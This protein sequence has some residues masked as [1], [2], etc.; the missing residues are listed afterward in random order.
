MAAYQ[1]VFTT[2]LCD[3]RVLREKPVG[4]PKALGRDG[5]L[6]GCGSIVSS[7]VEGSADHE[8]Q[9]PSYLGR[10]GEAVINLRE[11]S[12]DGIAKSDLLRRGGSRG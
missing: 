9:T 7:R 3:D 5:K 10:V 2:Q 8:M 12:V 6:V 11:R 1:S 4:F